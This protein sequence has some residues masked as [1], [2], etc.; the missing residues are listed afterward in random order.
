PPLSEGFNDGEELFVID[1]VVELHGQGGVKVAED[2]GRGEGLFEE[3]KYALAPTILVPGGVLPGESVERFGD[4]GVVVNELVMEVSKP[5]EGLYLFDIL[6]WGL[7]EDGL[8]L[9]WIHVYSV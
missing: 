2:W 9:G 1:L 3:G 7:V 8:D 5:Q 6:G 4:P